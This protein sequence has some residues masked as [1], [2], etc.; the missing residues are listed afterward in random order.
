MVIKILISLIIGY[1]LGTL[2]P[3]A[4][5]AKLKKVNLRKRGTGNLGATNTTM[6][7]GKQYGALVMI[8]D[9]G[10]AFFACK[11]AELLFP[12]LAVAGLLAGAA[13]VVGH[14]FPFYMKFKGGK[15][16]AAFGGMILAYNPWMFLGLLVG[17]IVLM[18]LVNYAIVLPLLAAVLFPAL[19]AV[20][21][22]DIIAVVI[23]VATSILIIVKHWSIFGR[24]RRGED[25]K[26]RD[27]LK[28]RFHS[29]PEH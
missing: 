8:I 16:L 25:T 3:A 24:I 14:I 15:G 22:H 17:G 18:F 26:V 7:L 28:G 5:F 6:V 23:C 11:L 19:V 13:A 20:T 2:S 27:F 29:E 21:S 12:E 1:L 4:L 10:K 9:I